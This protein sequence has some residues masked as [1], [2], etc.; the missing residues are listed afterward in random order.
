MSTVLI[1]KDNT[2]K[3]AGF[4][5]K[6]ERAY[7]RFLAAVKKMEQGELL[8][9][10]YKVPRSPK[11]H[12]LHFVMLDALFEAQEQFADDYQFRKWAEVGAGHCDFVPGPTGRMVA[13]AR[14]IDYES[15]DDAEFSDMHD[16][17]KAFFKS[18]HASHF[19]WPH[20]PDAEGAEMVRV[21]LVEF[22]PEW[23]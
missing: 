12:R 17:V 18:T 19:L 3:L 22:E 14:S 15:L 20:L 21:I 8:S 16:A 9:F 2:G 10:S 4:G 11:F 5:E 6:G 7:G 23:A 1:T 13:L